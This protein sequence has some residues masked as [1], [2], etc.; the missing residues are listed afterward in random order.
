MYI[1]DGVAL[2]DYVYR[3]MARRRAWPRPVTPAAR[4]AGQRAIRDGIQAIADYYQFT[5]PTR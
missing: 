5:P 2:R 1:A 4:A 3:S